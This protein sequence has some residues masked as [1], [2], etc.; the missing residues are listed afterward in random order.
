[1]DNRSGSFTDLL[2]L[3]GDVEDFEGSLLI[4]YFDLLLY[5]SEDYGV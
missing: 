3:P 2:N 1:M 4:Y 5:L